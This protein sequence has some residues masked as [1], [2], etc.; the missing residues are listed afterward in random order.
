MCD[1]AVKQNHRLLEHVPDAF[2][3]Q[4]MCDKAVKRNPNSIDHIPDYFVHD[5]M[6][7]SS[8]AAQAI[9]KVKVRRRRKLQLARELIQ[10]AWHPDRAVDWCFDE[11]DKKFMEIYLN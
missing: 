9:E 4:T 11:D 5:D 2:K 6:N 10:I 1:A 7:L 8:Y 3:T